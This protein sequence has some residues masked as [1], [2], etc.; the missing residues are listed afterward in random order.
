MGQFPYQAA[1][2]ESGQFICGGSIIDDTHV[3][4][5]AHCVVDDVNFD[6]PRIGSPSDFTV[7]HGGVDRKQDGGGDDVVGPVNVSTVSVD[8]RYL[9]NLFGNEYDAALL[10]L[11]TPLSF[12]QNTGSIGL[13]SAQELA[14]ALSPPP[15]QATVSGWGALMFRGPAQELLRWVDVPLVP[16]AACDDVYSDLVDPVM[17]CAGVQ[18]KDACQGDSGG[19]LAIDVG[20]TLTLAGITSFG[21]GCGD[22]PGVYTEVPE[23]G[24]TAFLNTRPAVAPPSLSPAPNITGTLPVGNTVTCN[25]SSP[26]GVVKQQYFWYSTSDNFTFNLV[27]VSGPTFTLSSSLAGLRIACTSGSRTA[28]ASPIRRCRAGSARWRPPPRAAEPGAAELARRQIPSGRPL[29]YAAFAA[30]SD[31]AAGSRSSPG[32]PTASST[33]SRRS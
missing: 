6:Y 10:T 30:A 33:G 17:L 7:F 3:V 21:D 16:D 22:V 23:T 27:S 24:V 32:T 13:A 26:T 31:V 14:N 8:R 12:D 29:A 28:A 11:A 20:G 2:E 4:T 15:D 9:R 19:P 5:A 25:R 1:L 18:G